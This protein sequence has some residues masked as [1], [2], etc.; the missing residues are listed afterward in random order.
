VIVWAGV[1]DGWNKTG[2]GRQ[3]SS[4]YEKIESFA[5]NMKLFKL[6]RT[7]RHDREID[8]TLSRPIVTRVG[9]RKQVHGVGYS[10]DYEVEEYA[11]VRTRGDAQI[12]ARLIANYREIERLVRQAK[13][14]PL[15]VSYPLE[16]GV[17]VQP[18]EAMRRAAVPLIVSKRSVDPL[19]AEQKRLLWAKHPTKFRYR[20]IARDVA[21][22]LIAA[23]GP[24][25]SVAE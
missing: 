2:V 19:P 10:E 6:Y 17:F 22:Q 3:S 18:N 14:T 20:A 21:K 7:W 1:N 25:A 5:F 4:F 9:D 8:S 11:E 13:A 15:F 16:S 24:T 23:L 12:S